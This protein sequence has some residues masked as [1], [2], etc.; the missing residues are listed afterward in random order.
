MEEILETRQRKSLGDKW[1]WEV[2]VFAL[3]CSSFFFFHT[4]CVREL[5][6]RRFHQA[7]RRHLWYLQRRGESWLLVGR[8]RQ[9]VQRV[10][11]V[12]DHC[13][14]VCYGCVVMANILS[15]DA[16]L[17]HGRP[18]GHSFF[19]GSEVQK[20]RSKCARLLFVK[21]MLTFHSN[22][23]SVSVVNLPVLYRCDKQ[24]VLS[25]LQCCFLM[26]MLA[27]KSVDW[28]I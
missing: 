25:P 4:L 12:H 23:C 14:R 26:M 3:S 24:W 13:S 27:E 21:L 15:R 18:K 20:H 5:K 22:S 11:C 2:W 9:G 28:H 19:M 10:S 7:N 16:V 8:P 17:Y 1:K 6:M